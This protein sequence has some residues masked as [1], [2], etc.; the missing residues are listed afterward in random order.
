MGTTVVHGGAVVS[1]ELSL[2][3]ELTTLEKIVIRNAHPVSI[4]FQ[5]IAS[6]WF[7]FYFWNQLWAEAVL[8]YLIFRGVG[9]M[10]TSR[11]DVRALSETWLGRLALLHLEGSNFVVQIAGLIPLLYGIWSHETR[12]VLAGLSLILMGH[13]QGWARVDSRFKL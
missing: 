2:G 4:Y 8:S 1:R 6:V 12:M 11:A 10:A 9:I 5:V 13:L 7:V 3:Q